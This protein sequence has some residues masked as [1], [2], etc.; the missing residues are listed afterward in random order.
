M[1]KS[2]VLLPNKTEFMFL[3]RTYL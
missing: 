2:N 1:D 3:S